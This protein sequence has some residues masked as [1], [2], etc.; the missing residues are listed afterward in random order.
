M[1]TTLSTQ[2]NSYYAFHHCTCKEDAIDDFQSVPRVNR[3]TT[4]PKLSALAGDALIVPAGAE[5]IEN[6][7]DQ[8]LQSKLCSFIDFYR[9]LQ[10]MLVQREDWEGERRLAELRD[11]TVS[12]DWLWSVNPCHGPVVPPDRVFDCNPAPTWCTDY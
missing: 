3:R 9:N 6:E 4:P 10:T 1:G 12:H 11:E 2:T 8:N 7:A 5:I